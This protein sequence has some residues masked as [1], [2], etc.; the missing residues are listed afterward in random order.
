MG[1]QS[2]LLTTPSKRKCSCAPVYKYNEKPP[3]RLRVVCRA[4]RDFAWQVTVPGN[5]AHSF[6]ENFKSIKLNSVQRHENRSE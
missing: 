1:K 5:L 6:W 2:F 3:Y 4:K